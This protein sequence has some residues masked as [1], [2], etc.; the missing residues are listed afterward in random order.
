V[1]APK[2]GHKAR[3]RAFWAELFNAHNLRNVRGYFAPG[4]TNHNARP[5]TPRRPPRRQADRHP[6]WA[7]CP[8]MHFDLQATVTEGSKV[9]CT[10]MMRHPDGPFH[11]IAATHQP[12]AARWLTMAVI[13][14]QPGPDLNPHGPELRKQPCA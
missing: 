3:A 1:T 12:T 4:F 2:P 7:A 6:A 9:V 13:V 14:P 5:G 8:D 11:G 10:A